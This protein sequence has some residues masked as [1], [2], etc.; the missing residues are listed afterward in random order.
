MKANAQRIIVVIALLLLA[1][2][3]C[4]DNAAQGIGAMPCSGFLVADKADPSDADLR[5]FS[6]AQGFMSGLNSEAFVDR[7]QPSHGPMLAYRDLS[8]L[9][10]SSQMRFLRQFCEEHPDKS[11]MHGVIQLYF[12]KM[13][14]KAGAE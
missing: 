9:D 11:Y 1:A 10:P 13:E 2:P 14:L 7:G 3:A 5:F 8:S 6:W 12:E 4:A